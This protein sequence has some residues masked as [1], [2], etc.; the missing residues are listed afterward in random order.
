MRIIKV[1]LSFTLGAIIGIV[2]FSHVSYSADT[3]NTWLSGNL[4]VREEKT[5]GPRCR[6]VSYEG[7]AA[8]EGSPATTF[9]TGCET[10]GD[11]FDFL[12]DGN[13][14]IGDN[15]DIYQGIFAVRDNQ[16]SYGWKFRRIVIGPKQQLWAAAG[17]DVLVET[18]YIPDDNKTKIYV[19]TDLDNALYP[20]LVTGGVYYEYGINRSAPGTKVFE[21]D[22]KVSSL[23][24]T[25]D[26]KY[27]FAKNYDV[28]TYFGEVI[29]IDTV[30]NT[31]EY[32]QVKNPYD[33]VFAVTADG[34]YMLVYQDIY[35]M[36]R[37]SRLEDSTQKICQS[38]SISEAINTYFGGYITFTDGYTSKFNETGS[39]LTINAS[40][41]MPYYL[42]MGEYKSVTVSTHKLLDYLALGDSYSSGEGDLE[43]DSK[44]N[45]YY[46][47]DT[48]EGCH[49]ST[50]SYPYLLRKKW[51]IDSA[52]MASVACSGALLTKDYTA[53]MDKY[54]GQRNELLLATNTHGRQGMIDAAFNYF[55]PG[56]VPQIE[57]V[58]RYQPKVLTVTG[59][60]NDVGFSEILKY[61]AGDVIESWLNYTCEYAKD[62][63]LREVLND[64]IDS[65][66]EPVREFIRKVQ[67]ASPSTKIYYIGYP[68]FIAGKEGSCALNN[69]SL[70]DDEREMINESIRRLNNV[71]HQAV[72]SMGVE[73]VDIEKSLD[74]GRLC[75][76]S[77]YMTGLWDV[78]ITNISNLN[79]LQQAFHPNA[80]GHSKIAE[81]I[82]SEVKSLNQVYNPTRPTVIAVKPGIPTFRAKIVKDETFPEGES[83]VIQLS[84]G[85]TAGSSEYFVTAFSQRTDL[86]TY[87]SNTDGSINMKIDLP[88]S[89]SRGIHVILLDIMNSNGDTERLYQY[90]N[91][92]KKDAASMGLGL[93]P[94]LHTETEAALSETRPK[95]LENTYL[96]NSQKFNLDKSGALGEK[97]KVAFR[98]AQFSVDNPKKVS[99]EF[100]FIVIAAIIATIIVGGIYAKKRR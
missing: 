6:E 96:E 53:P 31:K 7:L 37:C 41:V 2:F 11:R 62:G 39:M 34:R 70:D 17:G 59:S 93:K 15:G 79:I 42:G 86:G 8:V 28:D 12:H 51:E 56:R 64:S 77:K 60:G 92:T 36:Q 67:K 46:T 69:G 94:T 13:R 22:Y 43:T 99:N 57:F 5:E 49:L 65:Q 33:E 74:G 4:F 32:I 85:T 27:V 38:R 71:I 10:K 97:N 50:R 88:Q 98:N 9:Y 1:L 16:L 58:K 73:Y 95:F 26:A 20:T 89:L 40:V 72:S 21:V 61:C 90:I 18:E 44:G 68:S 19:Y 80:K 76:G 78:G 47:A 52:E 24:L 83:L 45:R 14:K 100:I 82:L 3:D 91:I 48:L 63:V 81:S 75:E 35:D 23:K 25:P 55:V 54:N 87:K 84:P 29:K 30:A 66:Y